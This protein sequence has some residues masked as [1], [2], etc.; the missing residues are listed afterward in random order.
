MSRRGVTVLMGT[1]L[2]VILAVASAS[3]PVPYAILG[4]G[5]T[6]NTV[7]KY[8]GR[9]VI[10]VSGKPTS[11]SKGHLNL[12][13]VSVTDH[14]TLYEAMRGWYDRRYAVVPRESIFPPDRSEKQVDEEN[15]AEFRVS[16]DS[17]EVAALRELN[18]PLLVTITEVR[19]NAAVRGVLRAGDVITAVDGATVARAADLTSRV[20]AKK[21]GDSVSIRYVR[22]GKTTTVN[23]RTGQLP[24]D[25]R[26]SALGVLIDQRP[27]PPLKIAFDINDIGGPSAGLMFSLGIIDILTPADLTGGRFIAG[28]GTIDADGNVGP[29]GGIHQKLVGARAAGAT[30]FLTPAGNCAE[31]RQLIPKG[32]RLVKVSTLHD[33]L[34]SLDT[35]RAGSGNLPGCG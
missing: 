8:N 13:T 14:V 19:P 9:P 15:A 21:P 1:V 4:P 3:L 16:Q 27:T 20:R 30:V 24:G 29:I 22:M 10:T 33:A 2:L 26:R 35:V 25:P 28:T 7:G 31:A 12:T 18:Y 23:V 32:L 5:P 34:S 6:V 17:A 11:E